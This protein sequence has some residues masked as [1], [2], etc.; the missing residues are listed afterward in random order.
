MLHGGYQRALG[1]ALDRAAG[2]LSFCG[3]AGGVSLLSRF[4]ASFLEP[5]YPAVMVGSGALV[6]LRQL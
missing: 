3:V 1:V 4:L 2:G 5:L 6:T